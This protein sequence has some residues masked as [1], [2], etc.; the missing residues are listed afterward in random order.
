MVKAAITLSDWPRKT[1][2]WTGAKPALSMEDIYKF[3]Q[4]G[5]TLSSRTR[6]ICT[7]ASS[8]TYKLQID[9]PLK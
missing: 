3:M 8:H 5:G 4:R 2:G 9:G 7:M 6:N 1:R